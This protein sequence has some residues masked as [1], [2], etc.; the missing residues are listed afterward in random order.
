MRRGVVIWAMFNEKGNRGLRRNVSPFF[1]RSYSFD[2]VGNR[3][4]SLGLSP[5]QYNSSNQLTSLPSATYAYDSNGNTTSKTD[6]TGTSGFTWDYENRLTSVTLPSGSG[7]VTFKYDP[8][9]RRIQKSSLLG[10]TSYLYDEANLIEEMDNAGSALARYTQ[11]LGVDT[12]LSMVRSGAASYYELDGLGSVT[13]LSNSTGALVNTYIYDSFGKLSAST[14]T[15]TNPFQYTAREFDPETGLCEYRARYYDQNVGRFSSEDPIRFKAGTNFYVYVGNNATNRTD[16]DGM[17]FMKVLQ[18]A[19]S[20]SRGRLSPNTPSL[21]S[22]SDRLLSRQKDATGVCGGC[23]V[24]WV[25]QYRHPRPA[26]FLLAGRWRVPR[27]DAPSA[28]SAC[29]G[30]NLDV[31]KIAFASGGHPQWL[32]ARG[33]MG[34]RFMASTQLYQALGI[35]SSQDMPEEIQ[36]PCFCRTG[37]QEFQ[38]VKVTVTVANYAS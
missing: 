19:S 34:A 11:N 7:T 18:T 13:S 35:P 36:L 29:S 24:L 4:S 12:P 32:D 27:P 33:G 37:R 26:K 1:P 23:G 16:P 14:G 6:S 30:S 15:V 28:S 9:G 31:P 17:A 2:A 5:Y 8:F 10:T 25:W 20:A 21:P 3:L 38:T 22:S